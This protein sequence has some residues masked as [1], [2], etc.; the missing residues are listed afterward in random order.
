M[1]QIQHIWA[2]STWSARRN[3]LNRFT[4][5]AAQHE[6]SLT[7]PEDLDWAVPLFVESTGV[8]TSS[9]LSYSKTLAALYHRLGAKTPVLDMYAAALRAS[10]GTIPMHQ[11]VPAQCE[12]VDRLLLRAQLVSPRVLAALFLLWKSAAR[13]DEISRM[14]G[15]SFIHIAPD[16]IIVEW[17]DRTKTSRADPF[18]V[19]CWTVVRHNA[20]MTQIADTL[21][22]LQP[23]EPLLD[24]TTQQ[25]ASWVQQEDSTQQLSA[26][27]FKRGALDVLAGRAAAGDIDIKLLPL[28]AK[29][30]WTDDFPCTT[31]RYIGDRVALARML[32]TQ[33]A[34]VLL[35]CTIPE[36]LPPPQAAL[37][38]GNNNAAAAAA[39]VAQYQD[40]EDYPPHFEDEAMQQQQLDPDLDLIPGQIEEQQAQALA[41]AQPL[42]QQRQRAL[43]PPR[44]TEMAGRTIMNRVHQRR[45]AE[46][47]QQRRVLSRHRR[48]SNVL[49]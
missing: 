2:D 48:N 30:K 15:S 38:Q 34:T 42:L 16:E 21:R 39:A 41:A 17:L 24:W 3:L 23:E 5:F 9:K 32:R 1:S 25:F 8:S 31:L 37:L 26:H 46:A 33:D 10:G 6:I 45:A 11:A 47:A 7:S 20:P 40:Q 27:S 36:P 12:Q 4:A 22:E 29:H 18:R 43:Q 14:T 35:P 13:F 44:Q 19:S 28:L 49:Q